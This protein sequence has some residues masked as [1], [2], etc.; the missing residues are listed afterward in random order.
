MEV[1]N[2]GKELTFGRVH[3]S[4]TRREVESND[5]ATTQS[6]QCTSSRAQIINPYVR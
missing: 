2:T 3:Q 4:E 1:W 5:A 6:T